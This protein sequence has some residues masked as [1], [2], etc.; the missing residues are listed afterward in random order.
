MRTEK[1][2]FYNIVVEE[3]NQL[4][5]A[6]SKYVQKEG[7]MLRIAICD[8][9]KIFCDYLREKLTAILKGMRENYILE[10]YESIADF[11]R[12][13]AAFDILFLDV[14]MMDGNGI[15]LAKEYK[16]KNETCAMIFI[17]SFPEFVFEVFSLEAVDYLCKPVL[18]DKLKKALERALKKVERN[19]KKSL[20]I[21]TLHWCKSVRFQSILYCEVIDRK[22]YL[23]TLQEVIV[24]YGKIDELEKQL[25]SRFFR[26]HRSYIVNL[27]YLIAYANGQITLKNQECIPVSR[28][29]QKEFMQVMLHYM[30]GKN[31][32]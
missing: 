6:V 14:Q 31:D 25:D 21:Q 15:Q 19:G 22:L 7:C 17:S 20:F 5:Y 16:K 1:R 26:C 13:E 10:C 28:L 32:R 29:R 23:H 4:R 9:E 8:D 24:Y 12:A 3:G 18:E 2:T 30:K 11:R 27:D